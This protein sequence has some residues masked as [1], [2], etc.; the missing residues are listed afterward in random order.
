MLDIQNLSKTVTETNNPFEIY[1][2]AAQA[3]IDMLI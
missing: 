1:P 3:V 2:Q